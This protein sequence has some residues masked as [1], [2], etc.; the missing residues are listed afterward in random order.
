MGF[1]VLFQKTG[2]KA[3]HIK[4]RARK[5]KFTSGCLKRRQGC[6]SLSYFLLLSRHINRK[7][8]LE[9][10][11]KHKLRHSS[12]ECGYFKLYF[13]LCT[14]CPSHYF[15]LSF[16]SIIFVSFPVIFVSFTSLLFEKGQ[17]ETSSIPGVTPQKLTTKRTR[18]GQH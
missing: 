4:K 8:E 3:L 13:T 12:M 15:I 5:H 11:P 10:A 1:P 2:L 6:N 14:K 16:L 18:L 17:T 7:L 9:V